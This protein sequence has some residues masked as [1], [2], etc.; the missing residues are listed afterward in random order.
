MK[1]ALESFPPGSVRSW[2]ANDREQLAID[3]YD[4]QLHRHQARR[5]AEDTRLDQLG[6]EFLRQQRYEE[7]VDAWCRRLDRLS[8]WVLKWIVGPLFLLVVTVQVAMALSR[9]WGL[10]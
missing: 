1:M 2:F 6:Q 4:N 5:T 7:A 9:H 3:A 8:K 10:G